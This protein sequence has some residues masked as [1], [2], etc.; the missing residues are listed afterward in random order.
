[1]AAGLPRSGVMTPAPGSASGARADQPKPDRFPLTALPPRAEVR[2][3]AA[4]SILLAV[5]C[6]ISYWLTTGVLS[7]AYSVQ[8]SSSQPLG[9]YAP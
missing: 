1:M 4:A 5:A 3:A 8:P 9:E 2:E 6:L 7:L